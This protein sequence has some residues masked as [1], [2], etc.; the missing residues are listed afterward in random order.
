MLMFIHRL[1]LCQ[2]FI[3]EA[4]YYITEVVNAET[5]KW[6]HNLQNK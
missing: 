3:T 6:F 1:V 5:H 4:S 2:A